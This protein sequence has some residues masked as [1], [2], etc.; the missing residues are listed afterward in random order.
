VGITG[1]QHIEPTRQRPAQRGWTA[2]S[3]QAAQFS[4]IDST[5]SAGGALGVKDAAIDPSLDCD[6]RHAEPTRGLAGRNGL[7]AHWE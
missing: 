4:D 7:S 6:R 3:N 5:M 2:F 1:H